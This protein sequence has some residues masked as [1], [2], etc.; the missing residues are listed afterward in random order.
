MTDPTDPRSPVLQRHH[1]I[2]HRLLPARMPVEDMF[3]QA[4]SGGFGAV[5]MPPMPD[6]D[7][8]SA[9][10]AATA[11]TGVGVSAIV[12]RHEATG[13]YFDRLG[14]ELEANIDLALTAI[15][16]A[17]ELGAGM[18]LM[19]PGHVDA[20]TSAEESWRRSADVIATSLVPVAESLGVVLG[21]E[22]TWYSFL[23]TAKELAEFVDDQRSTAVGAYFDPGNVFFG[24]PEHW[25]AALGERI[26]G[27]HYKD[28]LMRLRWH[29]GYH[30]FGVAG[31]GDITWSK[32]DLALAAVGYDGWLTQAGFPPRL[33][34]RLANR[35]DRMLFDRPGRL[36]DRARATL[37]GR[38][39]DWHRRELIEMGRGNQDRDRALFTELQRGAR[40]ELTTSGAPTT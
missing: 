10:L 37:E 7:D 9:V 22:N 19:T 28:Y 18:V 30:R 13:A 36:A 12:C 21:I 17:A 39:L 8:L 16:N 2:C 4:A 40:D 38:R 23:L 3:A 11:R 5:E 29:A 35:A 26:V 1:A 20:G 6:P 33:R 25:V 31:S 14:D 15:R 24:H 34:L 32:V 27:V